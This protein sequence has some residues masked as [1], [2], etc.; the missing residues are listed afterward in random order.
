MFDIFSVV[1]VSPLT[2]WVYVVSTSVPD[3][4]KIGKTR[5]LDRR[6]SQLRT[7]DP[8][9]ELVLAIPTSDMTVT[10]KDAHRE[11]QN[12]HYKGELFDMTPQ[13]MD[14]LREWLINE[15]GELIPSFHS[16]E[17][18]SPFLSYRT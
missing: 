16:M 3:R 9:I 17:D 8:D 6:L 10:E 7:V 15:V 14:H 4:Y 1:P 12:C 5:Q 18:L 13:E 11:M 2:G